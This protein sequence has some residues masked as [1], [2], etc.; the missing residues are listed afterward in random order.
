MG[1]SEIEK[2]EDLKQKLEAAGFVEQDYSELEKLN[3]EWEIPILNQMIR[4]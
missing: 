4:M 1:G 2:F 3:R